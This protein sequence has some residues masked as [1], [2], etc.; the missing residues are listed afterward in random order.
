MGARA[1]AQVG[2]RPAP[3]PADTER[4]KTALRTLRDERFRGSAAELAAA[5]G[6]SQ[7]GVSQLLSGRTS[8]SLA[9]VR[10]LARLSGLTIGA[11][12]DGSTFEPLPHRA[13][14]AQI[15]ADA[16]LPAAAIQAVLDE[17]AT[18]DLPVLHWVRR[19]EAHAVL[20]K[21]A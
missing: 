20:S 11:L 9:T 6:L 21:V 7:S 3:D 2:G 14:A 17:E 19:I 18:E 10:R 8:P 1:R 16:G 5:L 4:L 15:A 12:L 13:L